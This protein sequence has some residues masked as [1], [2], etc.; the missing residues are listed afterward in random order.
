MEIGIWI[1][2]VVSLAGT[3]LNVLKRRECFYVWAATNA[4]WVG[5]DI[6]KDVPGQACFMAANFG[7]AIWGIIS[8]RKE[9][10][11]D[12]SWVIIHGGTAEHPYRMECER[13][14]RTLD[15]KCP[16]SIDDFVKYSK[17][18]IKSHEK[19]EEKKDVKK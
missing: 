12:C 16:V 14:G 5:I 11:M 2:A 18:F 19:C 4:I 10:T 13:C 6:C 17:I 15:V 7:T 8:W 3:I 9:K 1:V